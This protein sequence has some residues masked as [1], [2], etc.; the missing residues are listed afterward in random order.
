LL[1]TCLFTLPDGHADRCP[2]RRKLVFHYWVGSVDRSAADVHACNPIHVRLET[3][4]YAFQVSPLLAVASGSMPTSRTGLASIFGFDFNERYAEQFGFVAERMPEEA[5]GYS[6]D[7]ASALT[8]ELTSSPFQVAQMFYGDLC[9]VSL[10]ESRDCFGEQ[11]SVR[12]NVVT[13]FAAESSQFQS[14]STRVACSVS[15]FLEFGSAVLET[16]LLKRN[17]SSKVELPQNPALSTHYGDSNAIGVLVDPENVLG[18]A[19]SWGLF[20]KQNQETVATGH[21]D[22][23]DFPTVSEMLAYST[24]CSVLTYG[25]PKPFTVGSHTEDRVPS[26]C[27]FEAE[28]AFVKPDRWIV[29]VLAY[30]APL[31]SVPLSFLNQLAGDASQPVSCVD[32]VVELRV[33]SRLGRLDGFKGVGGDCM[34]RG[35]RARKLVD[36]AFREWQNIE[37]QR[38]FRHYRPTEKM[39]AQSFNVESCGKV[40]R[41]SSP[42]LKAGVSLR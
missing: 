23:C 22:A 29:N 25:Q 36:L 39:L 37:L 7:L 20:L 10:G 11:P 34:E 35:V 17:V 4:S 21:Q 28:Q 30:A 13:L 5:V 8:G 41:N 27:C 15:V 26:F 42:C 19:W 24:V 32:E 14:G 6:V 38:L 12:A 2:S 40:L 9:I 3:T 1:P 33:G 31:P 18:C 16:D